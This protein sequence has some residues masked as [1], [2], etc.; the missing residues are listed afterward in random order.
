MFLSSKDQQLCQISKILN[1]HPIDLTF[2]QDLHIRSLNQNQ[3]LWLNHCIHHKLKATTH[4]FKLGDKDLCVK[5]RCDLVI[6]IKATKINYSER[7]ESQYNGPDVRPL[8]QG[9]H[10]IIDYKVKPQGI[11]NAAADLPDE[12][13]TFCA[14]FEV[15]NI[16]LPRGLCD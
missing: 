1:F 14:R 10:S 3:K 16:D 13:N 9:L 2:E 4:A 15:N 7:M 11:A 12:L 6:V 8:W 5:S